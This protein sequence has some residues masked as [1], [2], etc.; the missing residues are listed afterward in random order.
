M[1][2]ATKWNV[3]EAEYR[4][5]I[6]SLR[7]IAAEHDISEGAIRKRAKKEEWAR[8][9]A[10]SIKEKV[11]FNQEPTDEFCTGGFI[12]V[13]YL[14]APERFYKIGMAK[15]LNSR[16]E[17][18]KCASPF[19]LYIAISFYVPNMRIAEREL[20]VEFA[21]KRV[22]GEWFKLNNSDLLNISRKALLI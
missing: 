6:K 12:Y 10:A 13:I 14:D 19:N 17:Q 18:H 3:V 20:H 11:R 21:E 4:A 2:E 22:R 9:L 5:G 15:N 1:S 16:F 7:T 8:D